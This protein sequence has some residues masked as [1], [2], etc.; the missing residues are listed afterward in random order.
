M[1]PLEIALLVALV[2][3]IIES[4]ILGRKLSRVR[5]LSKAW[6][7]FNTE[8]AEPYARGFARAYA[9]AGEALDK[10]LRGGK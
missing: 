6:G 1:S 3:T 8:T 7:S 5:K 10:A 9:K 2:L 4:A